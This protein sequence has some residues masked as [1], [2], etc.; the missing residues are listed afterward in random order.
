MDK[1]KKTLL[2]G[3]IIW[4]S[5][6]PFSSFA[7]FYDNEMVLQG[8]LQVGTLDFSL[9]SS[10]DNFV[11]SSKADSLEPGE[12]VERMIQVRKEGS[13]ALQYQLSFWQTG[14]DVDLCQALQVLAKHQGQIEYEGDL[15]GLLAGPI[16][17]SANPPNHTWQIKVWLPQGT[18][19]Q[20]A[21]K[22]CYFQFIFQGWQTDST[23]QSSSFFDQEEINNQIRTAES[24]EEEPIF[25]NRIRIDTSLETSY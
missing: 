1:M 7:Y 8:M 12:S 16:I 15:V 5:F 9:F 18:S 13:L 21:D 24:F 6:A 22:V 17:L 20:L 23:E 4:L 14:G 11:P 3:L 25:F 10:Q 2:I 19:S